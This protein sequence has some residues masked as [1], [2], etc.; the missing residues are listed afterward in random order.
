MNKMAVIEH[1]LTQAEKQKVDE[2][3]TPA[4][5]DSAHTKKDADASPRSSI[6]CAAEQRLRSRI[7]KF[8]AG[9]S[10]TPMG[11][12]VAF[13]WITVGL[14]PATLISPFGSVRVRGNRIR[15]PVSTCLFAA[16]VWIQ[17]NKDRI[18]QSNRRCIGY[19]N[20][21][22]IVQY[23][24]RYSSVRTSARYGTHIINS[25]T[26]TMSTFPLYAVV[27]AHDNNH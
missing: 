23:D 18:Q 3:S 10:L 2:K 16:D 6:M 17:T 4:S 8:V 13:N 21:V 24:T 19:H 7:D 25:T 26:A 9:Y 11:K 20:P 14:F 15:V 22:L 5:S 12:A 1:R 27:E